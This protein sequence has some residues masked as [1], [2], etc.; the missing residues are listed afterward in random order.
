[1]PRGEVT[2]LA[3]SRDGSLLAATSETGTVTLFNVKT[4]KP[5]WTAVAT[6]TGQFIFVTPS[7]THLD[8]GSSQA[9]WL[10]EFERSKT[11]E[12]QIVDHR[13]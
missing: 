5:Q 9:D 13:E 6:P 3:W 2:D 11:G 7:D 12:V 1:M 8:G 10:V 4:G